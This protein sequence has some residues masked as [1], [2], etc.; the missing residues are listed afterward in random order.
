MGRLWNQ[1]TQSHTVRPIWRWTRQNLQLWH[2]AHNLS[3]LPRAAP[4]SAAT[5]AGR[6]RLHRGKS[7]GPG[8][9]QRAGQQC[10]TR[11]QLS[12]NRPRRRQWRQQLAVFPAMWLPN[13]SV[14]S[15]SRPGADASCNQLT[16]STQHS[17]LAVGVGAAGKP[18]GRRLQRLLG[19]TGQGV[20]GCGRLGPGGCLRW[21]QCAWV[22][23]SGRALQ[24]PLATPEQMAWVGGGQPADAPRC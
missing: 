5:G 1:A 24:G 14:R 20:H 19:G 18:A 22:G 11:R 21:A 17:D 7:T 4:S 23:G 12:A 8:I 10:Q 3:T 13:A 2:L 6:C 16:G 9:T 15:C